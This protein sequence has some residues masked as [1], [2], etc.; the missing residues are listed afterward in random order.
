MIENDSKQVVEVV[1]PK[2][3]EK[4]RTTAAQAETG[5]V[6]CSHGHEI[7]IVKAL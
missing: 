6:K 2:C 4:V 3:K 7:P 1:C 5:V